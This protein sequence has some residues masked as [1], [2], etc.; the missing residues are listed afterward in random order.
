MVSIPNGME[1]YLLFLWLLRVF[2]GFQ[3]PTRWNS[4][5]AFQTLA[6]ADSLFQFPTGWNSTKQ[7][8]PKES[9]KSK[10]SI[11]NGMEFYLSLSSFLLLLSR[12]SIPNGME[13]Y[14]S[15]WANDRGIFSFNSQRDGILLRFENFIKALSMF[16]FPTGWNST[17]FEFTL[18]RLANSF[19]FPT[20]WNSTLN[21][22]YTDTMLLASF[23]SQRDGIL[24]NDEDTCLTWY[25]MFQFPTGWN[26]TIQSRI[27]R[28]QRCCFNSQR[29]GIL[30]RFA[31]RRRWA[32]S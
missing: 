10:V 8:L 4:T 1:F 24:R 21:P 29:D 14:L 19:Q 25:P 31:L 3:F 6:F 2:Q 30:P 5:L 7:A 9:A 15:F 12:V 22:E 11:P 13:F 27:I 23:N 18:A 16:Q 26:S 20:G 28:W 32:E 17:V